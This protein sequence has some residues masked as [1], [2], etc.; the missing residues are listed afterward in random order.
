MR[1]RREK[2]M[3][4]KKKSV[5]ERIRRVTKGQRGELRIK[6]RETPSISHQVVKKAV[7]FFLWGKIN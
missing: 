7:N 4:R 6:E 2:S 3:R 1:E 5:K